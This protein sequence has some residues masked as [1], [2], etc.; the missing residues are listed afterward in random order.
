MSN[1]TK[2][3]D[4]IK[5]YKRQ[6]PN[7]S[8]EKLIR[9]VYLDLGKR[10]SFNL[11]FFF[12]NRKTKKQIYINSKAEKDLNEAL[13]T[14]KVICKT[15]AYL[16][17]YI[18]KKLDVNIKT[19]VVPD[20]KR[21]YPHVY[22]IVTPKEG[23]EYIIDLQE[24]MENIQSYSFTRNFGLSTEKGEKFVISKS[25]I[26]QI[27]R[28]L[29]YINDEKYYADD[30]LYLLKGYMGYFKKFGEKVEFV[31]EN[32]DVYDNKNIQYQE[33]KWHHSKILKEL[34]SEEELR[35][36][37]II[38]CYQENEEERVYKNCIAVE[39]SRGTDMYL[40]SVQEN[41]YDKI[42]I[43]EFAKQVQNGLICKQGVPG[44]RKA[45]R[46]L[47]REDEER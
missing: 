7:I 40:Y 44:L 16:L 9:F 22:N 30:Y 18:L 25:D 21:K 14:N 46:D 10:F 19:V 11:E 3:I 33:R 17:E 27:D 29:G 5:E 8:E 32:I 12:R 4:K 13:E 45:L 42:T 39:R 15:T 28:E 26:E 34:F 6:N 47:R 37:H 41:K 31:L 20:D 38:D 23:K 36:I 1:L 24:D 2:Y 35:K 43:D